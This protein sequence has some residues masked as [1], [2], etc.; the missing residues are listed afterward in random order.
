MQNIG[1]EYFDKVLNSNRPERSEYLPVGHY[2]VDQFLV[3]WI[4][5]IPTIVVVFAEDLP[6]GHSSNDHEG[7]SMLKFVHDTNMNTC[8]GEAGPLGPTKTQRQPSASRGWGG[9]GF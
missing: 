6:I 3:S 4:A 5:A 9:A 2:S 7:R 8:E 1:E